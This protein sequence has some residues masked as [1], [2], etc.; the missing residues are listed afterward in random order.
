VLVAGTA[1]T[2]AW[3]RVDP[4]LGALGVAAA[5]LLLTANVL[6]WYALWLLPPLVLHDCPPALLFTGTV[7]LAYLVYPP[8][9]AGQ[10]WYVGWDVRALEY[11]PVLV[12]ALGWLARS[13]GRARRHP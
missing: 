12:A 3:R 8:W 13:R 7:A 5:S 9:L 4:A 1:L 10:R 2:L 6:P 11:G